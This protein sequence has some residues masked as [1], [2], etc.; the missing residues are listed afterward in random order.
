MS[1]PLPLGPMAVVVA[2]LVTGLLASFLV[3][4]FGVEITA[5]LGTGPALIGRAVS[6]F[7]LTA[8][9]SSVVGGRIVDRIGARTGY[10]IGLA[11]VAVSGLSAG[12]LVRS[13]WH[14]VVALAI[15]GVA[16][17]FIDPSI[18]RTIIGAVAPARQG[19]A[20]GVKESAVAVASMT[21]GVALP[22]L[23][24]RAGWQVPFLA[25]AA[26]AIL[27]AVVIP[28]GI[29]PVHRAVRRTP[30]LAVPSSAAGSPASPGHA[31]A[32]DP[33]GVP[34]AAAPGE[35]VAR[36][37][38]G[39]ALALLA[40]AAGLAGGSGAVVATYL[41]TAGVAA[42]LPQGRA[43]LLL[44]LGSVVSIG[45]RL[46][47]GWQADRLMGGPLKLLA[48]LLVAGT[49]GIA[50]LALAASLSGAGTEVAVA[51]PLVVAL[52]IVG[53]VLALGPGWG[54]SALVFLVAVRLSPGRPAQSSGAMVA[55]LGGGGA[56][57]PLVAGDLVERLGFAGAWSAVAACMA[58][59]V[60]LVAVLHR[61]TAGV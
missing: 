35:P 59:A 2:A 58:A 11:A 15:G 19:T 25:V 43:A 12:L 9:V 24:G 56:V 45:V 40:V 51:T 27:L 16:I 23:A 33:T 53:A 37:G 52:L 39:R 36:G 31:E 54:W 30:P 5:E 13:G 50:A 42:G 14:L 18:A 21:A 44:S 32:S 55:G 22:L 47:A 1:E 20:F 6:A 3:G 8:A 34:E 49:V 41:V 60:A 7:F 57:L 4:A 26:I 10:R 38:N 48:G 28:A 29:D 61:R 46:A 17:A